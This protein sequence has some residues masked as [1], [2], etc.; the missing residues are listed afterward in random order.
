MHFRKKKVAFL[1]FPPN[2]QS[3]VLDPKVYKSA[4]FCEIRIDTEFTQI[5][6]ESDVFDKDS[7]NH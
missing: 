7:S 2:H 3:I 1:Y 4:I 5:N 6:D